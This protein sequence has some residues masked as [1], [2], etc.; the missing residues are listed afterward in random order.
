MTA[1]QWFIVIAALIAANL[2]FLR[3]HGFLFV[4]RRATPLNF[5]WRLLEV[6]VW[7]FVIGLLARVLE[8]NAY[9]A[10]YP[11][12]WEF[13]AITLCLFVVLAYPGFVFRYLWR[14]A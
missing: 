13:Y 14:K 6:L 2:P 11:Q 7:Y 5:A 12:H 8:S 3:E 9:A 4:F 10:A 1:A